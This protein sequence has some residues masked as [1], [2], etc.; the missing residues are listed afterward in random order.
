M[1]FIT[2]DLTSSFFQLRVAEEDQDYLSFIVPCGKFALER[3]AMGELNSG[4]NLNIN[5]NPLLLG[6]EGSLKI[7]DDFCI[8]AITLDQLWAWASRLLFNAS[9]MNWKFN[10]S[11]AAC[12]SSVEFCGYS[13]NAAPDTTVSV[14]P[15]PNSINDLT[16]FETPK[17]RKQ[18]QSLLG[19]MNVIM[20]WIP[21]LSSISASIR[22]LNKG[23]THFAWR[24]EH[25]AEL[26]HIQDLA[27]KLLPVHPFKRGRKTILYTDASSEGL[28][29][30][31]MQQK[32]DENK[33]LFILA[34]STG[35]KDSHKR[36][37]TFELEM[38]G[39]V[40]ALKKVKVYLFGGHPILVYTDHAS[41]AGIETRPM[42]PYAPY[43][44]QRALED[45]LSFNIEIK[46]VSK[47]N[48][49]IA[50]YLSRK[51]QTTH[52]APEVPRHLPKETAMVAVTYQ[53]QVLDKKL[54]QLIDRANEDREYQDL[55]EAVSNNSNINL[56]DQD[57]PAQT[58]KKVWKQLT[59]A[60][61]PNGRLILLD[62]TRVVPP[63]ST[64]TN[65]MEELH[66]HHSSAGSMVDTV[67]MSYYWPR[68]EL[69][70]QDYVR[71]CLVCEEI[72]RLHYDAPPCSHT[73]TPTSSL[74]TD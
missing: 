8:H 71:S 28:G 36:Y 65:L 19:V 30:V 16:K 55:V 15:S 31:L 18:L 26:E 27:T 21:G 10:P 63:L 37:S 14:L 47:A 74:E 5:T 7:I 43:R 62:K 59:V 11:K 17:T 3:A 68:Y 54:I 51:T 49:A 67:R 41:L 57:H 72:R 70:I 39:V 20:K 2:L 53:G 42:D 45:I 35:L 38:L 69:Q 24:A 73:W 12:G 48:N 56:L 13:L 23:N 25:Q 64:V 22:A 32:E 6:L 66:T 29:M 33:L 61:F 4:D 1:A 9:R 34:A 40:W 50:D 60:N 46:H 52:E 58:F 44:T